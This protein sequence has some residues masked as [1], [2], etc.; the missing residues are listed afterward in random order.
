[1]PRVLH[2]PLAA[3][4][5]ALAAVVAVSWPVVDGRRW[6]TGRTA[7]AGEQRSVAGCPQPIGRRWD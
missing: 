4:A 5:F 3:F 6:E 2:Q 1:M 7:V